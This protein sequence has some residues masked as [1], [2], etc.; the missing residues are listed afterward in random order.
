MRFVMFTKYL[1]RQSVPELIVTLKKIGMDGADMAVRPGFPVNP[2]NVR[3]ALPEAAKQFRDAGLSIPLVSAPTSFVD[4]SARFAEELWAACHDAQIPNVKIGYWSYKGSDY[5]KLVDTAR[6]ALDGFHGL[7]MRFGVKT[8]IHTHS[9]D[10]LPVNTSSLME[11]LKGRSPSSF[12]A[13][14]DPGHLNLN[15]EPLPM[16]LDMSSEFLSLVAVKDSLAFKPKDGKARG[17]RF[18][19]LGEGTVDWQQLMKSLTARNFQGTLSLHSE[20][21]GVPEEKIVE[22]TAKDLVYLKGL[23]V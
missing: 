6:K 9:G 23:K 12:A 21:D 14:L 16:A 17:A 15:G 2:D 22:Q 7:A 19:P 11:L 20:Y 3:K 13:Y 18:V 10:L 4:P 8:A 1:Q 5:W